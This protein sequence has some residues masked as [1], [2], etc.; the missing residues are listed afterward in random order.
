MVDRRRLVR[1]LTAV[2]AAMTVGVGT[3]AAG[4]WW[5][6]AGGNVVHLAGGHNPG[7]GFWNGADE[8][9]EVRT[10]F[11]FSR[12]HWNTS[13][14]LTIG[15]VADPALAQV[16]AHDGFYGGTGWAGLATAQG[17]DGVQHAAYF[18]VQAN[19]TYMQSPGWTNTWQYKQAVTCHEIGHAVAGITDQTGADQSCMGVGYYAVN[20]EWNNN[21][22]YRVPSAHDREHIAHLWN[23]LH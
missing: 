3:A 13:P 2:V 18:D 4:H 10:R 11:E 9:G 20:G 22:N 23:T 16:R 8:D 1:M 15:N 5:F 14:Y 6:A 12:G 17:W 19:L 21:G 7:F